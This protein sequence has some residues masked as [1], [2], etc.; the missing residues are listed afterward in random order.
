MK[1]K[2][3]M[4]ERGSPARRA[5][6]DTLLAATMAPSLRALALYVLLL[7][8]YPAVRGHST[9]VPRQFDSTDRVSD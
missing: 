4:W 8:L 2:G 7:L 1:E 3:W 6:R 9:V 5:M